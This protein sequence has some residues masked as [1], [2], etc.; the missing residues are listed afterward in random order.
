MIAQKQSN[1]EVSV[2]SGYR[3]HLNRHVMVWDPE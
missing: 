1:L 2:V 3:H